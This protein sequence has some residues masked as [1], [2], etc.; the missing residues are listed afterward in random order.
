MIIS[1]VDNFVTANLKRREERQEREL[2]CSKKQK[3]KIITINK[4]QQQ[5][6]MNENL[7]I[8][9]NGEGN[10]EGDEYEPD[11]YKENGNQF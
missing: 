8:G 4:T 10:N 9:E 11:N 7:D 2:L 5:N 1:T 3:V 6:D